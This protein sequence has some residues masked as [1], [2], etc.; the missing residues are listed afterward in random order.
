VGQAA[1]LAIRGVGPTK[2]NIQAL[3]ATDP[4]QFFNRYRFARRLFFNTIVGYGETVFNAPNDPTGPG[5][6]GQ[7]FSL[8][9][10]AFNPSMQ[11]FYESVFNLVAV[12][13]NTVRC[14][15][16]VEGRSC[17]GGL[18]PGAKCSQDP[19]IVGGQCSGQ[20]LVADGTCPNTTACTG[21]GD[22]DACA[23]NGFGTSQ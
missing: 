12:P 7:E 16:F 2:Q 4:Q 18:F 10:C 6:S 19:Y 21:G 5:V 11:P 13:G 1:G 14:I 17:S 20:G 22:I 9:V 23:N 15:D 8:S 3:L